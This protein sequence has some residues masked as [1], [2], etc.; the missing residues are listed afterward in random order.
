MKPLAMLRLYRGTD[1][2]AD[3]GTQFEFNK[4]VNTMLMYQTTGN[5]RVGAGLGFK[6]IADVNFFYNTNT[7]VANVA[8]QQYELGLSFHLKGKKQD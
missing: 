7:K 6:G 2:V 5:I 3:F 1:A 8:S 4:L